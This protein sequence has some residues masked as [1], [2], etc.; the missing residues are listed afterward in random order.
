[1]PQKLSKKNG[2]TVVICKGWSSW[3][4][5]KGEKLLELNINFKEEIIGISEKPRNITISVETEIN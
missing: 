5:I 3:G 1:M 2:L 4:E